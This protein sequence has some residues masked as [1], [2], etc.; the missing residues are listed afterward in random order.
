MFIHKTLLIYQSMKNK[1]VIA[2]WLS[3]IVLGRYKLFL[4]FLSH[5]YLL[6]SVHHNKFLIYEVFTVG[7]MS[8]IERLKMSY[9]GPYQ[10]TRANHFRGSPSNYL[11]M[12][13]KGP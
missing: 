8:V 6:L 2:K 11:I 12:F 7:V 1:F 9:F 4:Q 10:Y 13:K 3:S 5:S